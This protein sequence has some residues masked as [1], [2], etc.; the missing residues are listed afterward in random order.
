M[1]VIHHLL[2]AKQALL[3]DIMASK[4]MITSMKSEAY[5]TCHCHRSVPVFKALWSQ[6]KNQESTFEMEDVWHLL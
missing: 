4:N 3:N 6:N 2:L 5:F 1:K